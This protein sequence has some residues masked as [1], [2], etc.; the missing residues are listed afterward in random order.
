MCIF[1]RGNQHPRADCAAERRRAGS[2]T[3]A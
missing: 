3:D 1:R 2:G